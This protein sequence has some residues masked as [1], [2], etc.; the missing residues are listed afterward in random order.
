MGTNTVLR[1]IARA[2]KTNLQIADSFL[3]LYLGGKLDE[4]HAKPVKK[5]MEEM[6]AGWSGEFKKLFKD[7]PLTGSMPPE[8]IIAARAHEDLFL[9]SF[10][11]AYPEIRLR[12]LSIEDISPLVEFDVPAELKRIVSV[13]ALAIHSLEEEKN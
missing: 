5:I 13:Y 3:S 8:A 9:K 4:G 10:G 7:S 6:S 2:A 12:T 11:A 1:K